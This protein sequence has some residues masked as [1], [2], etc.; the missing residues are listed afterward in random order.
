M[1]AASARLRSAESPAEFD[2][3]RQTRAMQTAVP[4]VGDET[5]PS[6]KSTEFYIYLAAVA[7]VLLASLLV[8]QNGAG[9]DVF[10][11]DQAW[12]FVSLL[13]IGYLISRGLAK[14]GSFHRGSVGSGR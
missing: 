7:G 1:T 4:Q 12:W 14:A 2:R 5:K 8:G 9:D 6:V 13:T 11:A 3:D 10:P